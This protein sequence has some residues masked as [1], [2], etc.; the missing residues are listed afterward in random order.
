M[1]RAAEGQS[2]AEGG[3][4]AEGSRGRQKGRVMQRA[5]EGQSE[6]ESC[7]REEGCRGGRR[8]EGSRERQKG[9]GRPELKDLNLEFFLNWVTHQSI[10]NMTCV[11]YIF[12]LS[13]YQEH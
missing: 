12:C 7:R 10:D 9:R 3:R 11:N 1:H 5:A 6:A 4:R 13:V 8:A 2:D